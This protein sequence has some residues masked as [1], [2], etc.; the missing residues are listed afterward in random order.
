MDFITGGLRNDV[1]NLD[2]GSEMPLW[3]DGKSDNKNRSSD[4]SQEAA[5]P[6]SKRDKR[7]T[8]ND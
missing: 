1:Q 8:N 5:A 3:C 6:L 4:E 7:E 2:P